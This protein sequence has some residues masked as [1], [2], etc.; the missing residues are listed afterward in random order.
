[1][2]GETF[3]HDVIQ[4]ACAIHM[5]GRKTFSKGA[6]LFYWTAA[7]ENVFWLQGV[8]NSEISQSSLE[9]VPV[10]NLTSR[11]RHSVNL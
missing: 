11:W 6:L 4:H 2:P 10:S 8:A 3:R 7:V 9:A 1:M 5:V